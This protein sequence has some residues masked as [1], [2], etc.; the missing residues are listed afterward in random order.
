[1]GYNYRWAFWE[2]DK[3]FPYPGPSPSLPWPIS[4]ISL[5]HRLYAIAL[6]LGM[7]GNI[8]WH[9]RS[10]AFEIFDPKNIKFVRLD[11]FRF[12][13][14][15]IESIILIVYLALLAGAFQKYAH[16]WGRHRA[17][18]ISLILDRNPL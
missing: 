1:M 7:F 16:L 12:C 9:L 15:S 18:N 5:W 11:N 8:I 3:F 4:I 6:A 10:C 2:R 17:L 13:R 14:Q